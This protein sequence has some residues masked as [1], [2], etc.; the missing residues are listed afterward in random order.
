MILA[1][2]LGKVLLQNGRIAALQGVVWLQVIAGANEV[3][4]CSK[5]L[6]GLPTKAALSALGSNCHTSVGEPVIASSRLP[7]EGVLLP[8]KPT[9]IAVLSAKFTASPL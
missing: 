1:G 4:I 8:A 6:L 3:R 5:E 7:C 9:V 2:L